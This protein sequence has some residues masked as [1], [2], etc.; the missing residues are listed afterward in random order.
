[1]VALILAMPLTV[2]PSLHSSW[3]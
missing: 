3:Q 2:I 1:L